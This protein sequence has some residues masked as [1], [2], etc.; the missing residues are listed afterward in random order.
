MGS[1]HC[2]LYPTANWKLSL[3]FRE[4]PL[5]SCGLRIYRLQSACVQNQGHREVVWHTG[6]RWQK[7]PFGMSLTFEL[8]FGLCAL[9]ML[10]LFQTFQSPQF[11]S[12]LMSLRVRSFDP[13]WHEAKGGFS[14]NICRMEGSAFQNQR[15]KN[16]AEGKSVFL[17]PGRSDLR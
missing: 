8:S 2:N 1:K 5:L 10:W 6:Q 15:M 12:R 7:L 16:A 4:H 13:V 3:C 14:Q 11:Y 9:K 17:K